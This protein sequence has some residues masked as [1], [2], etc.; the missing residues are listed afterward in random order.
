MKKSFLAVLL[1]ATAPMGCGDDSPGT[2]PDA[3]VTPDTPPTGCQVTAWSAPS[4]ATNA[5]DALALRAQLDLLVGAN[6]MNGAEKGTVTI[7]AIDDL[8]AV[9]D[10]GTPAFSANVHAG[11]QPIVDEVF[12]EFVAAIAAG[13]Q[14]MV[15][16]AWNP[17]ANG[18]I[19]VTGPTGME[20]MRAFNAGALELRQVVDKGLFAGGALYYY[21]LKQTEGTITEATIDAIAAAWGSNATLDSTQGVR[22]DSAHYSFSMG[23]HD[24]IAKALTEAKA[25]AADSEC[26]AERDAAL[27]AVFRTWEQAMLARAFHYA[28]AA[29]DGL[30][31]ATDDHAISGALHEFAEGLGLAIGYYG[32]P[33]PTSGPLAGAG[34][35]IT[36]A[37]LD[38]I[39]TALRIDR[40]DLAASTFG[41]FV[42]DTT[43]FNAAVTTFANRMKQ[44]Y[45]LTDADIENYKL[46]N[47]PG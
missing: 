11:M 10:G 3:G 7:D 27:V 29:E 8:E 16:T 24:D 46:A 28:Y 37:D 34:R 6:T 1:C 12:P 23:F 31:T 19:W 22:T 47:T 20:S 40:T 30:A 36:D 2:Q 15:D 33:H 13:N 38:A 42:T 4:F 44:V 18:G 25:Y 17:P 32:L 14:D 21:A 39:L 5:A 9:Y 41:E 45:G 26:T 43:A 35:T